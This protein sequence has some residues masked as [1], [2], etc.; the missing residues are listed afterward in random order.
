MNLVK[1]LARPFLALFAIV[2][3]LAGTLAACSGDNSY[4][5]IAPEFPVYNNQTYCVYDLTSEPCKEAVDDA[6]NSI[7]PERWVKASEPTGYYNVNDSNPTSDVFF[8]LWFMGHMDYFDSPG[9][10]QRYYPDPYARTQ[11]QNH[12]HVYETKYSTTINTVTSNPKY[13]GYKSSK[14]VSYTGKTLKEK[15]VPLDRMTNDRRKKP[16]LCSAGE[17]T[18]R[19]DVD[20]VVAVPQAQQTKKPSGS[21]NTGKNKSSSNSTNKPGS[22][23]STTNN[24]GSN[25]STGSNNPGSGSTTQPRSK[26]KGGC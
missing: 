9:Y 25:K 2:G 14:G 8:W 17:I 21:S 23:K 10:L 12:V 16:L 26:P 22:N 5:N 24:P 19:V 4:G 20:N 6:G 18:S 11:Y 7:P 15:K 13:S 3:F 1:Q